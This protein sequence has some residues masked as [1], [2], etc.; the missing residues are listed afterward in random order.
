MFGVLFVDVSEPIVY[1]LY[2]LHI[3]VQ[4]SR[5]VRLFCGLHL[6]LRLGAGP[7]LRVRVTYS[8]RCL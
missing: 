2:A 3:S 8:G 4:R 5:S 1:Y 7:S 6:A